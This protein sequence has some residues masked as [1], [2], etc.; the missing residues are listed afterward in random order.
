MA[1]QA[2][3]LA[4]GQTW[5]TRDGQERTVDRCD[6]Y[7]FEADGDWYTTDG[8]FTSDG[9]DH[10]LDLVELISPTPAKPRRFVSITRTD[11]TERE[12][13]ECTFDAVADDGTAWWRH[14][15][16]DR[17]TQHPP[18]PSIEVSHD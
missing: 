3:Q 13:D 1:K 5:R 12:S 11:W 2:P 17:W 4:V 15:Y 18:L 9:E 14:S 16:E 8:R 7:P 6:D 10:P